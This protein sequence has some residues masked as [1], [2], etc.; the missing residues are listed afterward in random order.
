MIAIVAAVP[1][2][3]ELLRRYLSPCEVRSCGRR[4]LFR[5]TL[6]GHPALLLHCG[7]GKT[8]AAAGTSALLTAFQ[9]KAVLMVGC[10][11]AYL[12][13]DLAVGD[14]ALA[15]E[16]IF[17]DEGVLTPTGFLDMEKIGF[18]VVQR[19]GQFFFNRFPVDP[20]LLEK[21]RDILAQGGHPTPTVGPFVTVS[22]CSG[23][24]IA[25]MEL[26]RRTGGICENMEGAAVAQVCALHGIPFLEIRGISNLVEDRNP[27]AWEIRR[28]AETAQEA[29]R[30][31]LLD[32][33]EGKTP[34]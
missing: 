18:P 26:S 21:A 6:G 7:I 22:T 33:N 4:D 34:A 30:R 5:G 19:S 11:G 29:V 23:T 3:T 14:L 15:S 27:A 28:A 12:G 10:G 8:N 2:E 16:E 24:L 9:P 17:G 20:G 1:L 13:S 32:W 31:L 25:G